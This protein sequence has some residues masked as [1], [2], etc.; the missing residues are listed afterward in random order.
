MDA[1]KRAAMED[2]FNSGRVF[3]FLMQTGAVYRGDDLIVPPRA[4]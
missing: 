1:Q 4:A 3:T 2:A